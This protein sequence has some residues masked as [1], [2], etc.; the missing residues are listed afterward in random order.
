M[1]LISFILMVGVPLGFLCWAMTKRDLMAGIALPFLVMI[2]FP[3]MALNSDP[4]LTLNFS[5]AACP[6]VPLNS[7]A[8][9]NGNVTTTVYIPAA[10]TPVNTPV[11]YQIDPGALTV[12]T[13]S[14]MFGQL[15]MGF[16][17][18]LRIKDGLKQKGKAQNQ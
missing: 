7:T 11:T 8:T 4:A 1:E 2:S 17:V 9:V 16:V 18:M 14:V 15:I 10:C 5:Q 12:I 6:S 3:V 13:Y